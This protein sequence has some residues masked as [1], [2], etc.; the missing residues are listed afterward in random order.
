LWKEFLPNSD[1][2]F[3]EFDAKCVQRG[4]IAGMFDG[5]NVIVG[6]QGNKSVLLDW[7]QASG[8]DFD[9]I[10]DDAGHR[11]SQ[12]WASFNVL[13]EV[14]K[15]GGV[16]FIEDMHVGRAVDLG[17]EDTKGEHVMLNI[18]ISW[19]DQL[20][21]PQVERESL[22]QGHSGEIFEVTNELVRRYPVPKGLKRVSC[23]QH[24]CALEKCNGSEEDKRLSTCE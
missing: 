20:V 8:G 15:P 22:T 13:W 17:Y 24:A 7:V 12:I 11:N 1:I 3:A 21:L 23:Q 2:W 16:Y 4:S 6:D 19:V 10:V 18:L 9:V 5:V 14:L